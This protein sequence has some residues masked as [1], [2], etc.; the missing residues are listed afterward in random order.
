MTTS[1]IQHTLQLIAERDPDFKI[2]KLWVQLDNPTG[3]N[4]NNTVHGYIA[5]LVQQGIIEEGEVCHLVIGHT[6]EDIDMFHAIHSAL[7]KSTCTCCFVR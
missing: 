2:K 7:L 6:H 5:N 1:I 3:E 4:K